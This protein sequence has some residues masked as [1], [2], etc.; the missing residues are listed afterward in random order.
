MLPPIQRGLHQRE[1]RGSQLVDKSAGYVLNH[2]EAIPMHEQRLD[3]DAVDGLDFRSTVQEIDLPF[4]GLVAIGIVIRLPELKMCCFQQI[5][6][7]GFRMLVKVGVPRHV[8]EK[9]IVVI[10]YFV[11]DK[12][13]AGGEYVF[14]SGE[15]EKIVLAEHV[16]V[17]GG[18]A[19]RMDWIV[20]IEG[21]L[22]GMDF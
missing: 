4:A 14:K 9:P 7:H 19:I 16:V 5:Q 11:P 21:K 6:E 13:K 18:E 10:E 15:V 17:V 12:T 2:I 20:G 3:V 1:R 22:F 8:T